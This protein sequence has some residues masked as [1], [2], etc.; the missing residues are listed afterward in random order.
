ME[1][2]VYQAVAISAFY[3]K[4]YGDA[5]SYG[6]V[7]WLTVS[8]FIST[9]F[10]RYMY[11]AA[12]TFPAVPVFILIAYVPRRL[13]L[14]PIEELKVDTGDIPV[15]EPPTEEQPTDAGSSES[16]ESDSNS[17]SGESADGA[18]TNAAVNT[19]A[20]VLPQV[21]ESPTVPRF[22]QTGVSNALEF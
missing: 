17:E 20:E 9:I 2:F 18:I 13:W 14:E 10:P 3:A 6:F 19:S 4:S 8:V 22:E 21:G 16:E 15:E 11:I 1:I 5:I 12:D 7:A